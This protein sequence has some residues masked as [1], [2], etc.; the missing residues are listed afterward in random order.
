VGEKL[1]FSLML[2]RCNSPLD[3]KWTDEFDD[4]AVLPAASWAVQM[5]KQTAWTNK[6]QSSGSNRPTIIAAV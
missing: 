4:I 2:N 5:N 3:R 6:N 1:V